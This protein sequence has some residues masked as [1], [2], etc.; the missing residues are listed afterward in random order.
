[1]IYKEATHALAKSLVTIVADFT[2]MR[3]LPPPTANPVINSYVH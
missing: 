1:M 3:V 2:T